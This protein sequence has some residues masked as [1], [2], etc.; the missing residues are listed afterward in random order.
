M[1]K[2][3]T[4]LLKIIG[5]SFQEFKTAC[6]LKTQGFTEGQIISQS[7]EGNV[8]MVKTEKRRKEFASRLIERLLLLDDYLT[9]QVAEGTLDTGKQICLYCILKNDALFFEFMNEVFKE[10]VLLRDPQL[11][12]KDFNVFFARKAEQSEQIA[13][14]TEYTF[15]KMTQVYKRVLRESGFA[16]KGKDGLILKP[17][18]M[19][20]QLVRHFESKGERLYINAMRGMK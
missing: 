13:A 4:T 5:F 15:Y 6:K 3:Y 11:T 2:S 9:Q 7:V 18:I 20:G 14:W 12:E 1:S 19:D 17:A 16:V 8:F 10:K